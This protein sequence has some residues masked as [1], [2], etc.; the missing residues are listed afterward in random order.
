MIITLTYYHIS[1]LIF[2]IIIMVII[3]DRNE[4][5]PQKGLNATV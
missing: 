4:A 3:N 2:M 1:V 5:E